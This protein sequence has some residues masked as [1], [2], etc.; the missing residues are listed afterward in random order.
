MLETGSE[1]HIVNWTLSDSSKLPT[2]SKIKN[3]DPSPPFF[4]VKARGSN[5][6]KRQEAQASTV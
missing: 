4:Y 1:F 2:L 5:E 3:A 6:V